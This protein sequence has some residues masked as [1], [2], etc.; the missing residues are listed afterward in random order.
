M[1]RQFYTII[2]IEINSKNQGPERGGAS[3]I[4]WVLFYKLNTLYQ[5]RLSN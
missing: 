2:F 3:W 1:L 4:R 5:L